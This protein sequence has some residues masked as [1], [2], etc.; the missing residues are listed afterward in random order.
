L[1]KDSKGDF[2]YG[3][4]SALW[5]A[6]VVQAYNYDI[7]I[8]LPN[9]RRTTFAFTPRFPMGGYNNRI[10]YAE[11]TSVSGYPDRLSLVGRVTVIRTADGGYVF[12][13]ADMD[14]ETGAVTPRYFQLETVDGLIYEID[15]LTGVTRI[16]DRNGNSLA[17]DASGIH[18]SSGRSITLERDGA[19]RVIKATGPDGNFTEYRYDDIGDL[20][21]FIDP[22]GHEY[23]YT[24]VGHALTGIIGPDGKTI[25]VQDYDQS[26]RLAEIRDAEGQSIKILHDL[27]TRTETVVDRNGNA[28]SYRYDDKGN[29]IEKYDALGNRWAYAYDNKGNPLVEIDPLGNTTRMT[30]DSAGN[31]L[32]EWDAAGNEAKYT[33]SGYLPTSITDPLGRKTTFAF[34]GHN[35]SGYTDPLG[36]A[37]AFTYDKNGRMTEM[38]DPAGNVLRYEYEGT[39]PDPARVTDALGY[40]TDYTYD[41]AGRVK[42]ETRY[43]KQSDGSL[44]PL[45]TA[46]EYNGSGKVTKVT[47]PDGSVEETEYTVHGQVQATVVDGRRTEYFYDDGG[48]NWKT[49]YSD[50]TWEQL[51][52][53][54]NGNTIRERGRDGLVTEYRYDALGQLVKTIYPDGSAIETRYDPAGRVSEEIAVNGAVTRYEYDALGRA[55]RVT[56]ALGNATQYEYDAAG[57]QVAVTDALGHKT[58]YEYDAAG[59]LVRT[60][61]ADG[62]C[63]SY[64]YDKA[65]RRVAQTDQLLLTTQFG[66]DAGGRLTSVTDAL[67]QVTKYEYNEQG[68]MTAQIDA[69]GNATLFAYD[70]MGQLTEKTL[71]LGQKET[72]GYYPNGQ[73][74]YKIDPRGI[75]T[76]YEY[77]AVTQLLQSKAFS[78]GT[79]VD[80]TY[81]PDGSLKTATNGAGTTTY[82]Y[83]AVGRL[84]RVVDPH[85]NVISYTYDRFGMCTKVAGPGGE[86]RYTYDILGRMETV[87]DQ[88]GQVTRYQY[89]ELSRQK[90][91]AYANGTETVYSYDALSRLT[92]VVNRQSGAAGAIISSHK[93]TLNAAGQRI[94]IEEQ[95][96]VVEYGYDDLN[97]LTSEKR[98]G[99]VELDDS[100]TY[101]PVGNRLTKATLGES[102]AYVY[103]ANDRLL[104][105]G[106][107]TYGWDAAGNM[108]SRS[109][110]EGQTTYRYDAENR[111]VET[112]GSGGVVQY[113]YDA[114]GN[115]ISRTTAA[116]ITVFVVDPNMPYAQV[117]EEHGPAGA[118]VYAYGNDMLNVQGVGEPGGPGSATYWFAYDGLGSVRVLTDAG[119]TLTDTYTYE[120]FGAVAH[121]TGTTANDFRFT[122]EQYDEALEMYYLR[123]RYYEPGTGRF[124]ARDRWAGDKQ[125]PPSLNPHTYCYNNPISFTDPS[126]CVTL[127]EQ[128]QAIALDVELKVR[129]AGQQIASAFA[130]G[131][132]AVGRLWQSLGDYAEKTAM[133]VFSLFKGSGLN[134][135]PG[136]R[137]G[138]RVIDF[139]VN[140]GDKFATI[141]V[142]WGLPRVLGP[143]MTRLV[144]QVNAMV[145]TG[146]GQA[147]LWTL[148]EPTK[149]QL[150]L[151]ISQLGEAA[152]HVQLIHG[153]VE[154]FH[155][156]RFF[157]EI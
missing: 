149:Q 80:Y 26:G 120:A 35:L 17:R 145:G 117:L 64:T 156:I 119:G 54:A 93:Y 22:D 83:D 127:I 39:N 72:Y 9:G 32:S 18:H 33:Y 11:Y 34:S 128:M 63:V 76:D 46:Y 62:T 85:N 50:G 56:D 134:Y 20:V 86:L 136:Y 137:I 105:D 112:S 19:G 138:K 42:T 52:Y 115:R 49:T 65:G 116:G 140:L 44:L 31:L 154:L 73:M 40:Y 36:N 70:I 130:A 4:Q 107:Y 109:G 89:D 147:V 55:A 79:R 133:E 2:G 152:N 151:V 142:K 125:Y 103:D 69:R 27:G 68:Q 37:T 157:F 38:T 24:Y 13:G 143:A 10:G 144:G 48:R 53:D 91:T 90:K 97:R 29:V 21:T 98:D 15:R 99:V 61:L 74:E 7:T 150:N 75:R 129:Q 132:T 47:G 108:V 77:N 123:A 28:T 122:G 1:R 25:A 106:K 81:W 5:E 41:G 102:A 12:L 153:V 141:E 82:T 121:R 57:N 67:N 23:T 8:T 110:P 43:L 96:S 60:I 113:A 155:W 135:E 101:D 6:N 148:R 124:G 66:Y 88:Q 3:W 84:E 100:Y 114:E 87:T 131:G 16:S 92:S 58:A 59:R 126:G 111:L 78:D 30:Y 146:K 94:K 139:L 95:S 118:K 14:E 71:P 104:S 51:D 45:V